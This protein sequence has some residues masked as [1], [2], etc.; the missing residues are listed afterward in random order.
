MALITYK[1]NFRL[2]DKVGFPR[3]VANNLLPIFLEPL[4]AEIP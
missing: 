4:K 1:T 3:H 2:K